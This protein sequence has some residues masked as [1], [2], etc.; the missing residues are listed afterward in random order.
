MGSSDL[1]QDQRPEYIGREN[2]GMGMPKV[3]PRFRFQPLHQRV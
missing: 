1:N 2:A 3:L